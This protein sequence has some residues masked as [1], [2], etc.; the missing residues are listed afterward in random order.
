MGHVCLFVLF[1]CFFSVGFF[2]YFFWGELCFDFCL[3][4]YYFLFFVMFYFHLLR[5]SS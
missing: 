1:F 5:D 3:S 4:C 2:Y